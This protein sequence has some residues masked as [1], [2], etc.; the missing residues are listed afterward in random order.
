[1]AFARALARGWGHCSRTVTRDSSRAQSP[2]GWPPCSHGQGCACTAV[3][4]T[5]AEPQV[6]AR[7]RSCAGRAGTGDVGAEATA[8]VRPARGCARTPS[9]G[10]AHPRAVEEPRPRTVEGRRPPEA[11][12]AAPGAARAGAEDGGR[13]TAEPTGRRAC[14]GAPA[15]RATRARAPQGAAQAVP[16]RHGHRSWPGCPPASRGWGPRAPG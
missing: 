16:G 1:M 6:L 9:R 5:P 10:R 3:R 7:P 14:A 15:G 8:P 12:P 11:V 2:G 4:Q 13:C